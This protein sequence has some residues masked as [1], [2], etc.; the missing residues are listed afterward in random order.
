MLTGNWNVRVAAGL[1]LACMLA[2]FGCQE[3]KSP[4]PGTE[5]NP[6]VIGMS[7]CNLK[8]EPWRAQ[9][10]FNIAAAAK[11]HKDIEILFRDAENQP[12]VQQEHVLEFIDRGVNLIIVSPKDSNTLKGPITKAMESDIPVIVLDRDV[13]GRN[14]TCFIGGNNYLIGKAAGEYIAKILNGRGN[15]VEIMGELGSEPG[16]ERHRGFIDGLGKNLGTYKG[17][18]LGDGR[19]NIVY[20]WNCE[21]L[22]EKV[23]KPMS[24]AL[25][26]NE[27]IDLVYA[28][29]DPMAYAAWQA[30]KDEG[31]GRENTI[32]F[33]GVDA[34]PDVGL[35]YVKEGIL[36]ATFYYPTLGPEA[37]E[38]AMKILKGE[39]VP[40]RMTLPTRL[41][42]KE[43]IDK[44]GD[45]I[46]DAAVSDE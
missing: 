3:K 40:K 43:N 21:W 7:Q 12:A 20:A 39:K 32:K 19:I 31:K 6:W 35:K 8:G 29:N 37:I 2:V 17:E 26:E 13:E 11:K 28:H 14:Y 23:A 45:V 36:T 46:G 44:G 24:T 38:T 42:T 9:M 15:V 18:K 34:L 33:I 41:Y 16:K 25:A 5:E 4:P 22:A 1:L 10:N 30:A 27:R